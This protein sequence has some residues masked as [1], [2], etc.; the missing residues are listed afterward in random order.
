MLLYKTTR[1]STANSSLRSSQ[2]CLL[3]LISSMKS[4]VRV[5][6]I[7]SGR[8]MTMVF[9][10]SGQLAIKIASGTGIHLVVVGVSVSKPSLE[11]SLTSVSLM[12]L[13]GLHSIQR[14]MKRKPKSIGMV[15]SIANSKIVFSTTTQRTMYLSVLSL[16]AFGTSVVKWVGGLVCPMKKKMVFGMKS[17]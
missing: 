5:G 3:T 15:M 6:M 17:L 13:I 12:K 16:M 4:M 1:T 9:G 11:S 14:T 8:R 2:S 7:M 10:K